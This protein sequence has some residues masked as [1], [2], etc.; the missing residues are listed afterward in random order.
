MTERRTRTRT[1]TN[2]NGKEASDVGRS[3]RACVE[4]ESERERERRCGWVRDA[5]DEWAERWRVREWKVLV[6]GGVISEVDWLSLSG[7]PTE[8]EN[9]QN[10]DLLR[11]SICFTSM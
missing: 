10:N 2:P 7:A 6:W 9:K 3:V 5:P 11:T 4:R 1:N 8:F